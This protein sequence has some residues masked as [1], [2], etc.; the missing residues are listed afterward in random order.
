M[1]IE[2]DPRRERQIGADAHEHAPPLL[3]VDIE[4]VLDDPALGELQMPAVRD[5]V[6]DG[7]HDARRF[8]CL[9]YGDDLIGLCASEVRFDELVAA[10][11]WRLQNRDVAL[12]RP[13]LQPL[14]KAIG[15]PAQRLSAHRV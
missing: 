10:A 14:L 15:D 9:H 8:S 1:L 3:I 2:I 6:A 12:V 13:S 5:L 11:L 7:D 4:I